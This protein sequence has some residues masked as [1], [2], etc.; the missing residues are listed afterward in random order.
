MSVQQS[1]VLIVPNYFGMLMYI[2]AL[3]TRQKTS[4]TF[5]HQAV[6]KVKGHSG[7]KMLSNSSDSSAWVDLEHSQQFKDHPFTPL[8]LV[9]HS[10]ITMLAQREGV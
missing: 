1:C 4:R 5:C 9:W 2:P 8:I 6:A 10:L 3:E 7:L